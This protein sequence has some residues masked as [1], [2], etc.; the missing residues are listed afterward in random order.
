MS[1]FEEKMLYFASPALLGRKQA[2]L[3]AFPV[4]CLSDYRKEI[5]Y[6]Q[7]E[8]A[9]FGISI[10]YLYSHHQRVYLL[11][12]RKD[13]LLE[14]L[15][16]PAVRTFLIQEG[17]PETV[18]EESSLQCTLCTLR[19]H[20]L[21]SR[22]FPHEIGLFLGYPPEDV[23][24]FICQGPDCCK[25]SGCWKVYGDPDAAQKKFDQYKKCTRVYCQQHAKGATLDRL[26]V[27]KQ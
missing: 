4:S 10:E 16:K 5:E 1:D 21:N 26:A 15:R 11:V 24:G 22:E 14:Y 18:G 9:P 25:C 20:V 8:L 13:M 7:K 23:Q 19:Q 27:A 12:Y 17:Y 2:N 3:F 6:Y